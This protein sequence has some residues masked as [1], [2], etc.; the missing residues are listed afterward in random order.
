MTSAIDPGSGDE[1]VGPAD[2]PAQRRSPLTSNNNPVSVFV[3]VPV[4]VGNSSNSFGPRNVRPRG[5]R[6]L[7]R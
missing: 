7:H 5:R 6:F 3:F 1:G 4:F 2:G